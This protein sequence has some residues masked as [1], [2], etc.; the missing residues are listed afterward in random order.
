MDNAARV[1]SGH[2]SNAREGMY[3]LQE[4]VGRKTIRLQIM[5]RSPDRSY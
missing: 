2:P 4:S 3:E 1:K 5:D